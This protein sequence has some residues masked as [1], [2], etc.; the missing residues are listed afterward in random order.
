[1]GWDE[2]ILEL[3]LSAGK[4][5][6]S[7][8]GKQSERAKATA[9]ALLSLVI[10]RLLRSERERVGV[11]VYRDEGPAMGVA[12]TRPESIDRAVSTRGGTDRWDYEHEHDVN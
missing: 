4:G 5:V 8:Y 1:M 2:V 7:T 10:R 6:A 3:S 11:E 12:S 9:E